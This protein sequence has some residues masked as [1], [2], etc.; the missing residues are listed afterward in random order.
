MTT[1]SKKWEQRC[2][3]DGERVSRDPKI[4]QH[5]EDDHTSNLE[6]M[7]APAAA[8]ESSYPDIKEIKE[9]LAVSKVK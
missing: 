3:S 9:M 6:N 8:S 4:A 2:S 1:P 7:A 5:K